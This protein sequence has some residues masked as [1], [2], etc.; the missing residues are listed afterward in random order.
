MSSG[1]SATGWHVEIDHPDTGYTHTP[2]VIEDGQ[3]QP[4]KDPKANALPGIRIPVPRDDKW[5]DMVAADSTTP[6][7]VYLDGQLLPI[8][9]LETVEP[10]PEATVLRGRGGLELETRVTPQYESKEHHVAVEELV[11]D[12]TSLTTNVD[13]PAD[14]VEENVEVQ[15]ADST[16][17]FQDVT[18]IAD[19]DP[20]EI[21][22]GAVPQT[23]TAFTQ[24]AEDGSLSGVSTFQAD[25]FSGNGPDPGEGL[26]IEY[27]ANGE[28]A[29]W[30][31]TPEHD[32]LADDVAVYLRLELD[33]TPELEATLN[34][35]T[36]VIA[37]GDS[38]TGL[39]WR[40]VASN[41]LSG[42][43]PGY[44][45]GNLDAGTQYTLTIE[46]TSSGGTSPAGWID[47][48]A[49]LDDS[50]THT[51]DNTLTD[52]SDGGTYLDG[53]EHYGTFDFAFDIVAVTRSVAGAR[54][55]STW[56]DTSSGQAVAF[57]NDGGT[58]YPLS[59][60]NTDTYEDD[61]A[62][63]GES[64]RWR[65]TFSGFGT[66]DT[67][68]PRTGFNAQE[69]QSFT[70][71]ADLDGTTLL[72]DRAPHGQLKTLLAEFAEESDSVW[73]IRSDADG[74]LS[75]EWTQ[76]GQRTSNQTPDVVTY[77]VTK[78]TGAQVVQQANVYGRALEVVDESFTADHGTAV[79][80]ENNHL[81][82]GTVRLYDDATDP[83]TV[84]TKDA[85]Y[86]VDYHAGEITTLAGGD[87]S[88][89]ASLK[90]DYE[91]HPFSQV[92][93][94]GVASPRAEDFTFPQLTT[95]RECGLVGQR[96]VDEAGSERWEARVVIPNDQVGYNVVDAI[97]IPG[98]PT[99]GARH[100]RAVENTPEQT[101][102]LLASRQSI[103]DEVNQIRS[104]L[105]AALRVS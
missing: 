71:K 47:V 40:D 93:A 2:R 23:Q 102:L 60:A 88:D 14:A 48:V 96:I 78:D 38:E 22:S 30:T 37:D 32:I 58:T 61:F 84:Y 68:T 100:I 59:S 11:D 67:A 70:L 44:Q 10:T 90:V 6:M 1:R 72:V 13:A 97:D 91:Y 49:P 4:Q 24:E 5:A 64:I 33:N 42:T 43:S 87:I 20:V 77:D 80:L 25:R 7:R 34:G 103:G 98:V 62:D 79:S 16:S 57:S 8:E 63:L 95:D 94:S 81:E 65:A 41:P 66:R 53:P 27:D 15:S 85:D 17:E 21:D 28:S 45:G 104:Q 12:N 76:P 52:G 86:S 3:I 29:S 19:S 35:D 75:F 54:L 46:S 18:T 51:F 69:I 83:V 55:E 101:V 74:N 99:D 92:T 31:F 82:S 36:W 50:V 26:A 9:A 105:N 39:Q 89:G 73:E 56:N